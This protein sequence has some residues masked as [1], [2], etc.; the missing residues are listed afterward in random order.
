MPETVIEDEYVEDRTTRRLEQ[1]SVAL[2]I[3]LTVL[4]CWLVLDMLDHDGLETTLERA[5][6]VARAWWQGTPWQREQVYRRE[7]GHVLWDAQ[8]IVEGAS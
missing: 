4:Q 6:S 7:V 3:A 8:R 5:K 1:A 2:T